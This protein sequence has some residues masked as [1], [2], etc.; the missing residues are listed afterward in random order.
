MF[1]KVSIFTLSVLGIILFDFPQTATSLKCYNCVGAKQEPY[2]DAGCS[3]TQNCSGAENT[4]MIRINRN[5]LSDPQTFQLECK[6]EVDCKRSG[7][8]CIKN[9]DKTTCTQCCKSDLCNAPTTFKVTEPP[10][11]STSGRIQVLPFSFFLAT[12]TVIWF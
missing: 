6:A 7:T 2:Q 10:T 5:K 12:L 11:T 9:N 1:I 8:G 4:C 3:K